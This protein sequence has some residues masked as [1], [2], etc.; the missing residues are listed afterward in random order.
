MAEL[1]KNTNSR[2]AAIIA[3]AI[4]AVLMISLNFYYFT[5]PKYS[6]LA[7]ESECYKESLLEGPK[8]QAFKAPSDR[9][10]GINLYFSA[11]ADDGSSVSVVIVDENN[12]QLGEWTIDAA[13]VM[14]DNRCFLKFNDISLEKN[15]QYCVIAMPSEGCTMS[16][17]LTGNSGYGF[18]N[19]ESNDYTIRYQLEYSAFS[20][21]VIV[22]DVILLVSVIVLF[23]LYKMKTKSSHIMSI[24]FFVF[25]L[26]YFLITP[27]NTLYDEDGHFYRSYEIASGKM[28]TS[29]NDE[30]LGVSYI[31][32][33]FVFGLSN[34]TM[35]AGG[36]G[37]NFVYARQYQLFGY[38]LDDISVQVDNRNQ[39]LYSPAS[40]IPQ[41][42]GL[43][44]GRLISNNAYLIY[45]YGRF[46]AFLI[47]TIL[48]ILAINLIPKRK[49]LVFLLASTPVFLNQM[50]SYSADGNLNSLSLFFVAFILMLREKDKIKVRDCVILTI[51]SIIISL[52]KVIYFPLVLMLFMIPAAKFAKEK[53][54]DIFKLGVIAISLLFAV[55]WFIVAQ[56]YV[57]DGNGTLNTI[58]NMQ[59]HY[60][61]SHFYLLPWIVLN[62][63]YVNS[64][65]WLFSITQG[66][67]IKGTMSYDSFAFIIFIAT[68]VIELFTVRKEQIGD[69]D[70]ALSQ[71]NKLLIGGILF[72]ICTLT[73]GSLYTQ[74][75][76]YKSTVIQGIQGRYFIPLMIPLS[77]LIKPKRIEGDET[78][79][80]MTIILITA[81]GLLCAALNS[82]YVMM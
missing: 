16:I 10:T 21:N 25:A 8:L 60:A 31:P 39:A 50:I 72:V 67:M 13:S 42:I 58:R 17:I 1:R 5:T 40:Y 53:S 14:A 35:T 11:E 27:F 43:L 20:T 82:I 3:I 61:L 59:L 64:M 9:V 65:G 54:A 76:D 62:T 56:S 37:A 30:G 19:V 69:Y 41:V 47:N 51:C 44:F 81:F 77:L 32:Q 48:V 52:S 63:I 46:F 33:A 79:R 26:V 28:F 12:Y 57:F 74:W 2:I 15:K 34:I 29:K 66:T 23:I 45:F 68:I 22:V 71:K 24:M 75:T 78:V 80:E 18:E 55:I 7:P 36:T 4:F 70:Y 49:L 6:W 38:E 73:F